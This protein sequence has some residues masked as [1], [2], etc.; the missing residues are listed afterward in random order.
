MLTRY[1][2]RKRKRIPSME[3]ISGK[4]PKEKEAVSEPAS[5]DPVQRL[6]EDTFNMILDLIPAED[7]FR[8]QRVSQQWHAALKSWIETV[9]LRTRFPH[10]WSPD[11]NL[12]SQLSY[13]HFKQCDM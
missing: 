6:N 12:S 9:G 5:C 1:Q 3:D 8:L 10:F 7:L 11:L 4:K 13:D 2:R